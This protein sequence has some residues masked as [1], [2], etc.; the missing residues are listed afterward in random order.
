MIEIVKKK[1]SA[2]RGNA[3]I[4]EIGKK[5][6]FVNAS[7]GLARKSPVTAVE[8]VSGRSVF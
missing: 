1:T 2:V 4:V 8:F 3:I 5:R 7:N 6:R